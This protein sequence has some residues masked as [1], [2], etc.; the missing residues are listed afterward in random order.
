MISQN[1]QIQFFQ[2]VPVYLHKKTLVAQ[3]WKNYVRLPTNKLY[4]GSK[5]IIFYWEL[6]TNK[7]TLPSQHYFACLLLSIFTSN[8]APSHSVFSYA[9]SNL[10]AALRTTER[11]FLSLLCA[12][13]WTLGHWKLHSLFTTS[14]TSNHSTLITSQKR[15]LF[16][17]TPHNKAE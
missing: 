14:F 4:F 7:A 1:T 9:L 16:E 13:L 17:F 6:C 5:Y 2:I 12:H 11:C 10:L 3:S 15:W 8:D